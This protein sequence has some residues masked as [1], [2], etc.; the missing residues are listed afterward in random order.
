M[1][2]G[3]GLVVFICRFGEL[4]RGREPI[5]SRGSC[6]CPTPFDPAESTLRLS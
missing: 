6:S 1:S 5:A 3:G 2:S 4:F